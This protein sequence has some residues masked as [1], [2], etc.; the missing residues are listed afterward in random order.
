MRIPERDG[1]VYGFPLTDTDE[2]KVDGREVPVMAE[3]QKKP[4]WKGR[5]YNGTLELK[6]AVTG[7]ET[8]VTGVMRRLVECPMIVAAAQQGEWDLPA[9]PEGSAPRRMEERG[10]GG[11]VE[12]DLAAGA[13]EA[14]MIPVVYDRGW[15]A[16]RNGVSVPV[17]K[18]GE[19]MAVRL[20]PGR[21]RV[22]F[23]YF[24]PLLK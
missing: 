8:L 2:L 6:S 16:V 23:D 14:L 3:A 18:V 10:R 24:P 11:H 21:N 22:V 13:G 12:V 4:G 7:G 17:E 5:T 15:S 9:F 20:E 19:L 1:D